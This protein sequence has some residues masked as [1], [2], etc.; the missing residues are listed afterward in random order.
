MGLEIGDKVPEFVAKNDKGEKFNSNELV[1]KKPFVIYF[2][3]KN[4]TP[5]CVKEACD[6]RDSYEDFKILGVDVIGVSSDSVNSHLKFKNKYR[7]PFMF[8]SDKKGEIRKLFGVKPGLFGVLPGRET[9]V[10]DKN[11]VIRLKFN[12]INASKHL[13]KAL[14]SVKKYD[15]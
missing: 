14:V 6:F 15:E 8:L 13:K 9:Y 2:Y 3:P 1:G 7:L 5:G 11:G 10:V 12:S 4:F